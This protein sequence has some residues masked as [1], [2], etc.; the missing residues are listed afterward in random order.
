[1]VPLPGAPDD[2]QTA[3]ARVLER[4]G[5]ALVI[6]DAQ[7]TGPRL[8]QEIDTLAADP[9][10]LTAMGA[11]ARRVGRPDAVTA[12]AALARSHARTSSHRAR[13]SYVG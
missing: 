9:G 4:A 7:C 11:A 13:T 10:L 5:A 1:L 6:S 3:N 8:A 2:H 12:V